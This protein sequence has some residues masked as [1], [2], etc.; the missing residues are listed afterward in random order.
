MQKETRHKENNPRSRY[1]V[2]TRERWAQRRSGTSL[3]L[4]EDHLLS[5][6]GINDRVSLG[7]PYH[8][9][10]NIREEREPLVEPIQLPV[11]ESRRLEQ[12]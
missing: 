8:S 10:P 12:T 11:Q 9:E 7:S 3:R 6:R 4:S 1:L 5:L 2:L